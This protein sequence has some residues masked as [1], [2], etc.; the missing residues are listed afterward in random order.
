MDESI[1]NQLTMRKSILDEDIIDQMIIW[2]EITKKGMRRD[3]QISLKDLTKRS[4]IDTR[5]LTS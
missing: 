1:L 5:K 3:M 4:E 2:A